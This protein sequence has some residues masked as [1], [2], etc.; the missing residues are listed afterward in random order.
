[1]SGPG[2]TRSDNRITDAKVQ[3]WGGLNVFGA[4]AKTAFDKVT[5]RKLSDDI[6]QEAKATQLPGQINGPQ[7][8]Y[9]HCLLTGELRRKFGPVAADAILNANEAKGVAI[10]TKDSYFEKRE[11]PTAGIFTPT[12]AKETQLRSPSSREAFQRDIAA[13]TDM[14][15]RVNDRCLKAMA[16]ANTPE[17]IRARA[18]QLTIDAIAHGGNG[19]DGSLPYRDRRAW[20]GQHKT[21]PAEFGGEDPGISHRGYAPTRVDDILGLPVESWTEEDRR[22]V[23]GDKR[24]YDPRKRDPRI[25]ARV[26]KSYSHAY[27]SDSSGQSGPVSVDAYTR[28][29]GTQVDAHTRSRPHR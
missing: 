22:A 21:I 13:Q 10:G 9:R 25:V 5:L 26:E 15:E 8:V 24:Y 19:E 7:D 14:D 23:M 12:Y 11:H 16:G 27:G 18:K 1:M 6:D 20:I 28:A 2:H 29:D 3:E 4:A 17:E